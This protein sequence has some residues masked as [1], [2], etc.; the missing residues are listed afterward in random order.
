MTSALFLLL[1][2]CQAPSGDAPLLPTPAPLFESEEEAARYGFVAQDGVFLA[3]NTLQ[4]LSLHTSE[5]GLKLS[6]LTSEIGLHLRRWGHGEASQEA[7]APRWTLGDCRGMR[8]CAPDLVGQ[9]EGLSEWYR[10]GH[11]GVQQGFEVARSTGSGPLVLEIEVRGATVEERSDDHLVFRT[12]DG[13]MLNYQGLIAWDADGADLEGRMEAWDDGLRLIIDTDGA[14]FPIT[15][16]P[17]LHQYWFHYDREEI[18]TSTGIIRSFGPGDVNG[19][20]YN[21]VL[22]GVDDTT[23]GGTV[24]A[25]FGSPLGLPLEPAW[26]VTAGQTG[27]LFGRTAAMDGD[28][29]GDGYDDVVVGAPGYDYGQ[30]NEGALFVYYGGPDGPSTTAD[31]MKDANQVSAEL[32][33]SVDFAGDINNDGYDDVVAG[34][35]SYDGSATDSG[36]V[37]VWAGSSSGLASSTLWSRSDTPSSSKLGYAV[38]GLGDLSGDGLDDVG[39]T[40]SYFYVTTGKYGAAYV[41]YGSAA[42]LSTTGPDWASYSPD[43]HHYGVEIMSGGDMNGDGA[44][45]L[46][47]A[48]SSKSVYSYSDRYVEVFYGSASGLELSASW[49]YSDGG[50]KVYC[51]GEVGAGGDVNG[52]GYDDLTVLCIDEGGSGTSAKMRLFYGTSSGLGSRYV[53]ERSASTSSTLAFAGD[54]EPDGYDEMIFGGTS[55]SLKN[56]SPSGLSTPEF[57]DW[58]ISSTNSAYG[59][60]TYAGDLNGDGYG[61]VAIAEAPGYTVTQVNIYH[62]SATGFPE[63]ASSSLTLLTTTTTYGSALAGNC[64]IN[65]DGYDDLIVGDSAYGNGYIWVH[66][67]S[68][69]GVSNTNYG[70]VVGSQSGAQF[71]ESIACGDVNGD[72]LDDVLVGA[73]KHD[74]GQTD[75]GVVFLFVGAS[76]GLNPTAVWSKGSDQNSARLGNPV[77]IMPDLNGDGYNDIAAAAVQ[78]DGSFTNEG[79]IFVAYGSSSIPGAFTTKL[80]GGQAN[81]GC[82]V[83]DPV[84]DING[85]GIQDLGMG[86]PYWDT[87]SITNAGKAEIYYGASGGLSTTPALQIFGTTDSGFGS[88]L[89]GMGDAN[90]D[91]L[92]ELAIGEMT[93]T[94][95]SYYMSPGA[96]S[97]PTPFFVLLN[98]SGDIDDIA[99]AP[100]VDNDGHID[101][102]YFIRGGTGTSLRHLD[103]TDL[104][105]DGYFYVLDCDDS[106]TSVYLGATEIC[107]GVDNDCDAVADNNPPLWYGDADGDGFGDATSSVAACTAPAGAVATGDDCDDA[108]PSVINGRDWYLDADADGYGA[109][110]VAAFV[111]D[112]PAGMTGLTGDCDDD[113]SSAYPGA[114]EVW[115][116]GVDQACDE[117]SDYDAD[118][119]GFDSLG[120]GGTDCDDVRADV[121]PGAPDLPYDGIDTDC[122]ARSDNDADADGFD[123][124][125]TGGTDCDDARSDVHPGA[126]EVWY[127]GAD[128]DCDG[129][130]DDQDRDGFGVDEDCDDLTA[131]VNPDGDEIWYDGVDQDCDGSSDYDADADGHEAVWS[132]GEDCDDERADIFPGAEEIWYDG[133]DQSCDGN[134][135]DQDGDGAIWGVD[136]DDTNP[137]IASCEGDESTDTGLGSGKRCQSPPGPLS[138]LGALISLGLARRRRA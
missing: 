4:G 92:D 95:I 56:G 91:G 96:S 83:V 64:D 19:D 79:A 53:D 31:W 23:G 49:T 1:I 123:S 122:S 22:I 111:C 36:G 107:D 75:E 51:G 80:Q 118:G 117:G 114:P 41:Y 108:D 132:G 9:H 94:D 44:D 33:W 87:S 55:A 102:M 7:E 66:Y 10:N 16:D 136:C 11:Q 133:V 124:I 76:Y 100:D 52:D 27:A 120:Y 65:N 112:A 113:S 2:A 6:G 131:A 63:T 15:V 109:S 72:N 13:R 18:A 17:Y 116:D 101:L 137:D 128:Q 12:E 138:L 126:D 32:G 127:D 43:E 59:D 103:L 98:S 50:L 88:A 5:G 69:T 90:G 129:N 60:F 86:C 40:A 74:D 38:A 25:Y 71:G 99:Q 105:G 20:G 28:V 67:G 106:D 134:D 115:Y 61:D 77:Q 48:S 46:V 47:I 26:T 119:D 57:Y 45:E 125:A 84:G 35:P 39:V 21:D 58:T 54:M 81:I 37:F 68:S 110:S 93:D 73:T 89:A 8:R 14:Q 78:W 29:N 130:D 42:G 30:S 34:A 24:Y 121:Y 135:N 62:G 3:E 85:D 97:S 104:D 70:S 82:D